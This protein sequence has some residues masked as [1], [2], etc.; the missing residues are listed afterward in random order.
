M[1]LNNIE[2]SKVIRVVASAAGVSEKLLEKVNNEVVSTGAKEIDKI[3]KLKL[4]NLG[5]QIWLD[6]IEEVYGG[7][8]LGFKIGMKYHEVV[9]TE[10]PEMFESTCTSRKSYSALRHG[11]KVKQLYESADL[12]VTPAHLL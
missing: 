1:S 7:V 5:N 3:S 10:E 11:W 6:D 4:S 2:F 12:L 9:F 8:R